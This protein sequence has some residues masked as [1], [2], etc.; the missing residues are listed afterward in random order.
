MSPWL[1]RQQSAPPS[2]VA[3]SVHYVGASTAIKASRQQVW[4]FIKPAENSV[5]V[6]PDVV[7]AFRAPGREGEGEI[8]VF[9]SVRDGVETVSAIEV[10][11]EIPQELAITRSIGDTDTAARGRDFLRDG[12]D[13]TTVLEHGSYFTLPAEAAGYFPQYEQQYKLHARQYVE[14]VKAFLERSK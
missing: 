10:V 8:Q 12:E 6:D 13:G 9:I 4:D 1:D 5:L 3:P 11:H 7:R 14:R 2:S